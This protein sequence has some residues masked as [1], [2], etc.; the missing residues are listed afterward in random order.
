MLKHEA[1]FLVVGGEYKGSKN[2]ERDQKWVQTIGM[3]LHNVRE[4][5]ELLR[6]SEFSDVR[7]AENYD[8]GWIWGIGRKY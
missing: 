1:T 2:D 7:V 5:K 8:R 3:R 6:E 4:S